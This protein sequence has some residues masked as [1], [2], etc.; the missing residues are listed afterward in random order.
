M[1]QRVD[2]RGGKAVM[3]ITQTKKCRFHNFI[4][5]SKIKSRNQGVIDVNFRELLNIFN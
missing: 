3:L 4:I 2:T 5:H 1:T